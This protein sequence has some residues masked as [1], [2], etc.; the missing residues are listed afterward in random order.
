MSDEAHAPGLWPVP[1]DGVLARHNGLVLLSSLDDGQFVD[2]LLDLLESISA[3]GGDGRQFADS[4]ADT[5]EQ[6]PA[7]SAEPGAEPSVLAFGETGSGLAVTVSGGAWADVETAQGIAHLAASQPGMLLRCVL[8]SPFT[9]VRGGLSPADNGSASTDRFSR[10]DAGTIRAGGLAFFS[11]GGAGKAKPAAAPKPASS[12]PAKAPKPETVATPSPESSVRRRQ[13]D[14]ARRAQAP[15]AAVQEPPAPTPP[16]AESPPPPTPSVDPAAPPGYVPTTAYEAPEQAPAG[17]AQWTPDWS[18]QADQQAAEQQAAL[19]QAAE[20]AAAQQRAAEQQ[21]LEAAA[22][23]Q[24]AADQQVAQQQ[25]VEPVAP[26]GPVIPA[27]P[28]EFVQLAGAGGEAAGIDVP[29]R[30]PLA[31]AA[32]VPKG[33]SSYVSQGPLIQGVYCTRGHFDDPEARFCAVCGISMNQQTLVPRPGERPPLGLLLMDD[34]SV[35]QLDTDYIIGREPNLD[36]SVA[37][38]KARPLRIADDSGIVSRVHARVSLEGWRVLVTDLGSA[39][40]T[41]VKLPDQPTD[42]Q[43]VPQVPLVLTTGSQVDVGGR[44]F[45]YESHRGR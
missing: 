8:R 45:R 19:E 41:R 20:A 7:A 10:L 11:A 34:G 38:G 13:A 40:G 27:E 28:F 18:G 25:A 37:A 22:A 29:A 44:G 21:A 33:T 30:Q 42:T 32:S 16:E 43:L 31:L 17:T 12:K 36:S 23:A 35:F 9:S 3:S 2:T 5:L 4:I 14:D 15:A 1:G 39:N 6:G 26:P 24:Q